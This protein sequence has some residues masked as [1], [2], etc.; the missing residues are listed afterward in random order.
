M[1][2]FI[3]FLSVFGSRRPFWEGARGRNNYRTFNF[4]SKNPL[5]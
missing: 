2:C 4:V 5:S 1:R 3:V